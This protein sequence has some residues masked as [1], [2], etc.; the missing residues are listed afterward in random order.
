MTDIIGCCSAIKT[1]RLQAHDP[2]CKEYVK[3]EPRSR[4]HAT[5][6]IERYRGQHMAQHD[7]GFDIEDFMDATLEAHTQLSQGDRHLI[8][9]LFAQGV[10]E[11]LSTRYTLGYRQGESHERERIINRIVGFK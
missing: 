3:P 8:V 5:K 9:G 6:P 4:S 2:L 10:S 11:A 7:G 1:P